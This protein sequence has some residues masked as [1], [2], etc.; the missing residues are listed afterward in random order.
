[1]HNKFKY[2]GKIVKNTDSLV[3][4]ETLLSFL[5]MGTIATTCHSCWDK[6]R[7]KI[8]PEQVQT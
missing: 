2:L 4:A 1:M 5:Q 3:T 7:F 8:Y 6:D